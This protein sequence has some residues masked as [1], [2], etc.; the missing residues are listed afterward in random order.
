ML[1][2]NP[3]KPPL[4]A[5]W[6]GAPVFILAKGFV[7]PGPGPNELKLNSDA[8]APPEPPKEKAVDVF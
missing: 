5:G 7:V 2:L 8:P 4:L 6:L 1:P 3:P